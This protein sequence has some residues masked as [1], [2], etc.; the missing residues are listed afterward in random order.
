MWHLFFERLLIVFY[1]LRQRYFR[2]FK[3][4]QQLERWQERRLRKHLRFLCLASPFYRD[5][6]VEPWSAT[7]IIDKKIMMQ[8]F[9][10][11]NTRSLLSRHAMALALASERSRDFSPMIDDVTIGLSS[12]TSGH[13]GL[14]CVDFYERCQ[15]AGTIIAK[16]LPR[17]PSRGQQ[18]V[19]F[20]L[21]A[22]SNLYK[23]VQSRSL[24]FHYFDL[25]IPIEQH[26]VDLNSIQ[27]T[28]VIGPPSLLSLLAKAILDGKMELKCVQ[29][30]FSVAE[31]L[32]EVDAIL[33]RKAFNQ[34]IHQIY[35]CTEGF[36]AITC[37]HGSLHLNEDLLIF[38]KEWIDQEQGKFVPILTDL[39]RRTQPILRYRLND[40]LTED[41]EPC[42][43]GSVMTRLKMIE[44]RCDDMLQFRKG[45]SWRPVFPDFIRR[46]I[47]FA[48]DEITE[49]RV[50]Q[51]PHNDLSVALKGVGCRQR[52]E[53]RV[54]EQLHMLA[55]G[56][57]CELPALRFEHTF[58]ELKGHKLRRIIRQPAADRLP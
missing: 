35:Q 16:A 23:S 50:T 32:D 26:F 46:A 44:G 15:Y 5:R 52:M 38:E 45:N 12:G 25:L 40:I 20:F 57:D 33:I 11:L 58:P 47:L 21:R 29:R 9:D 30:V 42:P 34:T 55:T 13:R 3:S 41:R 19:A 51:S 10:R 56:L 6:L 49:Y 18:R 54:R 37:E 7:E 8:N 22:N 24:A 14:F 36:L 27:P 1:F 53:E 4:R 2:R 17:G 39:T 31:V 28:I 43:C 48:S